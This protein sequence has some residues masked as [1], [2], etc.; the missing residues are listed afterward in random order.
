MGAVLSH[1]HVSKGNYLIGT[2]NG[3]YLNAVTQGKCQVGVS[4]YVRA[5]PLDLK[6]VIPDSFVWNFTLLPYHGQQVFTLTNKALGSLKLNQSNCLASC[7]FS[8]H[9]IAA[10]FSLP[11]T[12]PDNAAIPL[13]STLHV[14]T[15]GGVMTILGAPN[16]TSPLYNVFI[17]SC[18]G[19]QVLM[20]GV[21]NKPTSNGLGS[22]LTTFTFIDP[23]AVGVNQN[24]V[25]GAVISSLPGGPNYSPNS[26]VIS[27]SRAGN[28]STL[29]SLNLATS[30]PYSPS[31]PIVE[32][33]IIKMRTLPPNDLIYSP[34]S[35][36]VNPN[37]G[38]SNY[39]SLVNPNGDIISNLQ[40]AS[41]YSPSPSLVNPNGA[42]ISTLPAASSLNSNAMLSGTGN[43]AVAS[44]GTLY[45]SASSNIVNGSTPYIPP[46]GSVIPY[47]TTP[48]QV[49]NARLIN[50]AQTLINEASNASTNAADP[51]ALYHFQ[52]CILNNY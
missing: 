5:D 49:T 9:G 2:P 3:L 32:P 33:N 52:T 35:S 36:L 28:L 6:G 50:C 46:Q 17:G 21:N 37:T 19:E 41:N 10:D 11:S 22:N 8:F 15:N 27:E 23:V 42:S 20:Y 30:H 13:H 34:S 26:A 44:N 1:N 40:G 16:K 14:S 38:G 29:N 7:A 51:T 48:S 43:Y 18:G 12:I 45:S 24:V 4:N 39:S 47:I 25:P 31:L